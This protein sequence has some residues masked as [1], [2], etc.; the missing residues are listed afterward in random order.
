[1][2][3]YENGAIENVGYPKSNLKKKF[4]LLKPNHLVF[5]FFFW[6]IILRLPHIVWTLAEKCMH[7][8][9]CK[10]LLSFPQ[11]P[12]WRKD[13]KSPLSSSLFHPAKGQLQS[14]GG[15]LKYA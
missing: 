2:L 13:P 14:K 3:A 10:V 6:S 7:H 4:M 5:F 1:M 12:N 11:M 9:V 15:M 8:S